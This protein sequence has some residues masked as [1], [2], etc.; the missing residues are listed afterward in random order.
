MMTKDEIKAARPDRRGDV[1]DL[2][3]MREKKGSDPKV[4]REAAFALYRDMGPA[5]S[6][7]K[8]REALEKTKHGDVSL[9]T[10]STWAKEE[11]WGVRLA[12]W[13]KR[14]TPQQVSDADVDPNFNQADALL[15]TAHLALQRVLSS[16]PQVVKASDMKAL[17]D[18][19]LGAL[20]A[21]EL[22]N[23]RDV[24]K[25]PE[26]EGRA[27]MF[28][29]AERGR[30]T[31]PALSGARPAARGAAEGERDRGAARRRCACR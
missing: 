27:E 7:T 14:Q 23:Q 26:V 18:A 31:R 10:T 6:Y 9:R 24:D 8:L 3:E 5:R 11:H 13:D 4:K 30:G 15:R 21:V 2:Q 22:I 20:K 28:R 12:A 19:A 16:A 25:T 17:T 29:F 1:N